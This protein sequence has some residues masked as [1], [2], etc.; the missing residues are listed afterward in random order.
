MRPG[1]R[2]T[3]SLA[4]VREECQ[5][6]KAA[7]RVHTEEATTKDT[8]HLELEDMDNLEGMVS[9]QRA[10][11][12]A[13]VGTKG[14][15]LRLTLADHRLLVKEVLVLRIY[16]RILASRSG[17]DGSLDGAVRYGRGEDW[18]L[19]LDGRWLLYAS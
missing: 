10:T 14:V 11:K 1:T 9:R 16:R 8:P 4:S 17:H 15:P 19:Q 13:A 3:R 2:P 5:R 12:A 18:Y 6:L 7:L